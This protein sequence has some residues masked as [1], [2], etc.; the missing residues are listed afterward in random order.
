MD[1]DGSW[2]CGWAGLPPGRAA[3]GEA[4]QDCRLKSTPNCLPGFLLLVLL[5][6]IHQSYTPAPQIF[7][8]IL[9]SA[10][11]Q[12]STNFLCQVPWQTFEIENFFL[13]HSEWVAPSMLLMSPQDWLTRVCK[14]SLTGSFSK[15]HKVREAL[16][17][18]SNTLLLLCPLDPHPPT[19]GQNVVKLVFFF[20]SQ[21]A[22]K[23]Q[24]SETFSLWI[25]LPIS[26]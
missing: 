18:P 20:L 4:C 26:G 12:H 25:L 8:S 1:D 10:S 13:S 14:L 9:S 24:Q 2:I 7:A 11:P 3:D 21:K 6:G 15:I 22:R 23:V 16:K 17:D 5:N 19:V